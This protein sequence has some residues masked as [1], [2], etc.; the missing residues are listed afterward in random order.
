MAVKIPIADANLIWDGEND[1][2]LQQSSAFA[3]YREFMAAYCEARLWWL[4]ETRRPD[5]SPIRKFWFRNPYTA[6]ILYAIQ[7]GW[8]RGYWLTR[9][10]LTAHCSFVPEQQIARILREAK[11]NKYIGL[12]QWDGDDRRQKVIMPSRQL[13]VM[14]EKFTTTYYEVIIENSNKLNR[15]TEGLRER[16]KE[17]HKLDEHRKKLG[18]SIFDDYPESN[19]RPV[20]IKK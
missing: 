5:A 9:K 19:L 15:F 16:V 12:Q 14:F 11:E 10:E 3:E 6:E 4:Q 17:I 13:I 2:P 8:N 20:S 18:W 7:E 1:I